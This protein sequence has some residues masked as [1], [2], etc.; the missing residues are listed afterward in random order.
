MSP[1][2]R[3]L[4]R[5]GR[6][7][8]VI[9]EEEYRFVEKQVIEAVRYTLIG[10][11]IFPR[12]PLPHVG[13]K[14]W[15]KY[16]QTDMSQA[17]IS[18]EGITEYDD[19]IELSEKDTKVPVISKDFILFWRDLIASRRGGMPL[20]TLTAQNA[21]RQ[22][23]EEEDKL[24]IS[25]E[26]TGW[27][28]LGIEGLATATGRQT[29]ASAGAWPANAITDISDSIAQLE[30]QGHYGAYAV[31]LTPAWLATLRQ[32]ISN[33]CCTYLSVIL[34]SLMETGIQLKVFK[35]PNLFASD[36]GVDSALVVEPKAENFEVG[37]AQDMTT[38]MWQ[39]KNMNTFGKVY[40]V[41]TPKIH[42]ATSI[43]EITGIT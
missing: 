19:R 37:I 10:R 18:M 42:R 16:E 9:T 38:F 25:G 2:T 30:T 39:G 7:A 11:Q 15:R 26:Y 17:G 23:G 8:G 6:E 21:A 4:I 20:D 29:N 3:S 43:S 28:A 27:P 5:V 31:I 33:T 22:V 1:V 41:L 13:I 32:L 34:E 24:L 35:T 36:G 40:E 12:R 14:E